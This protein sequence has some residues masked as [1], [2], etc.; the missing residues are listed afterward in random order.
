MTVAQ[1]KNTLRAEAKR[2]RATCDPA[3]GEQMAAHV[4][5]DCPPLPG[6]IIGGFWPLSGEVDTRFLLHALVACGHVVTLP[7]TTAPG[8]ALVFRKWA[9]G[10]TLQAGRFGTS[11]P[12][13]DIL[14]PDFLLLPLLA[15]DKNGNRLGY[16]GG[17]YDRTLAA[18]PQAYRLGCGFAAQEMAEV[19][20][21]LQDLPLHAVATEQGV[22]RFC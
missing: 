4:L 2:R 3:L 16:G 1:T 8:N 12:G 13:G 14:A 5:R 21:G 19:P 15:F 20:A 17:Y 7:E 18:L 22:R 6:A 9:P 10:E 11:Y